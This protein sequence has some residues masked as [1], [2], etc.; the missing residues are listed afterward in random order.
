[1]TLPALDDLNALPADEFATAIAPLFE[2][3]PAFARRLAEARPFETDADLLAGARVVARAMPEEEQVALIDTHPRIGADPD[4]VSELSRPE[5]GYDDADADD[6][7]ADDAA[8]VDDPDAWVADELAALNEAY[9]SRF[10]FRFV[11]F[12]AG[13]PRREIIPILERAIHA[14]RD[15]E[16]RRALDDI[17]HIAGDR[18]AR[19]RAEP[20]DP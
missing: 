14:D 6:A 8:G 12:V 15:E 2:G 17:V 16:L 13:R 9:E 19:L 18:L 11:V 20:I 10:G 7:D 5:Q 4:T 1:M 3:A